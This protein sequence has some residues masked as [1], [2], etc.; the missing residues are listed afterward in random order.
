MLQ[1][2]VHPFQV[3]GGIDATPHVDACSW[4]GGPLLTH[5]LTPSLGVG[6]SLMKYSLCFLMND[7]I[8]LLYCKNDS[9]QNTSDREYLIFT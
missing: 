8:H 5:A 1:D 6:K 3:H 4:V 7:T 9:L 2:A